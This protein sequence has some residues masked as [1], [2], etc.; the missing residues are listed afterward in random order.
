MIAT[1]KAFAVVLKDI[2]IAFYIISIRL[3]LKPLKPTIIIA[4]LGKKLRNS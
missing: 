4:K 2:S 1:E 3:A